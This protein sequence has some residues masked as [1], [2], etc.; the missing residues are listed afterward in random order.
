M[1]TLCVCVSWAI[2]VL[3]NYPNRLCIV[4]HMQIMHFCESKPEAAYFIVT[5]FK[6]HC[7]TMFQFFSLSLS[8]CLCLQITHYFSNP[9]HHFLEFRVQ[10][11]CGTNFRINAECRKQKQAQNERNKNECHL[12]R[13]IPA[14]RRSIKTNA[15]NL[16]TKF[17]CEQD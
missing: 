15:K 5:I 16:F 4:Q 9:F 1:H 10:Q 6:F 13:S 3:E 11:K 7:I 14:I 2:L 8:L 17:E 12:N